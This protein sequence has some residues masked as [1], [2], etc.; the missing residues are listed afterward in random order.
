MGTSGPEETPT[1]QDQRVWYA[2][3]GSNLLRERFEVYL[4]GGLIPGATDGRAQ[5]GARDRSLPTEDRPLSID[6]DLYFALRSSRWGG[7][8]VAFLD[9]NTRTSQPTLGRAWNISLQQLADVYRQENRA[10]VEIEID[11]DHLLANGFHDRLDSNYGRLLHLGHLDGLPV[12]TFT[13]RQRHPETTRAHGSY[14][15][16]I[17]QGLMESWELRPSEIAHYLEATNEVK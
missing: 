14:L 10:P 16:V 6:H 5:A 2:A 1:A 9:P 7:G 8:G 3:F 12:L 17:R 13:T 11:L 4:T 15:E